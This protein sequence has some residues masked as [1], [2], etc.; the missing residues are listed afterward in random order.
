MTGWQTWT[1]LKEHPVKCQIISLDC[2][3]AQSDIRDGHMGL[4]TCR[5]VRERLEELG[6]TE[7]ETVYVLNHF[8]HNGG[9]TYDSLCVEAKKYGFTV[10]YDGMTIG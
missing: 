5:K 10:S 9:M 1:Y 6:F 8:S 2:T 4:E 7:K 3:L